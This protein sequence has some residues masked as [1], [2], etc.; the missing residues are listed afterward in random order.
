[1]VAQKPFLKQYRMVGVYLLLI[2]LSG[3]CC[4]VKTNTDPLI[5]SSWS[6]VNED[7]SYYEIYIDTANYFWVYQAAHGLLPPISFTLLDSCLVISSGDSLCFDNIGTGHTTFGA[8]LI[9]IDEGY[10]LK[11]L[12]NQQCDIKQYAE[13]YNHRYSNV[14]KSR[15]INIQSELLIH[16]E[17]L[18]RKNI[19]TI[20]IKTTKDEE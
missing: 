4:G 15:G 5:N 17:L 7:S 20:R 13:S 12:I 16:Y 10:T 11:E 3:L 2:G 19:E 14:M 6:L 9:R 18:E 1:M 8:F